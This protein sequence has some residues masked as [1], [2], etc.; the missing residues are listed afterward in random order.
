MT[1]YY[2]CSI[3]NTYKGGERKVDKEIIKSLMD[4]LTSSINLLAAIVSI[5]AIKDS[6][7][8]RK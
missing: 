4:W 5:K 8:G 7:K 6:R 3:I 2:L 1:I